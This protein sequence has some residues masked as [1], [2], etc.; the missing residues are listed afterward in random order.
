MPENVWYITELTAWNCFE[1]HSH[2]VSKWCDCVPVWFLAVTSYNQNTTED[3][4]ALPTFQADALCEVLV[5]SDYRKSL[6]CD[7]IRI[8][9][10]IEQNCRLFL[11]IFVSA[12]MNDLFMAFTS[13]LK[14]DAKCVYQQWNWIIVANYFGTPPADWVHGYLHFEP[15]EWIWT[16]GFRRYL[17]IVKNWSGKFSLNSS[18]V[19]ALGWPLDFFRDFS[20]FF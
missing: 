7:F 11:D 19:R 4:K 15:G 14:V 17:H 18:R 5:R 9:L 8:R 1:G 2:P 6:P 16:K 20:D 3:P 12:I 10:K 13:R